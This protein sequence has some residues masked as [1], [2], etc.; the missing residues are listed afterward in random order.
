MLRGA[1][2]RSRVVILDG[3]GLPLESDA[4]QSL[5]SPIKS[6]PMAEV[7]EQRLTTTSTSIVRSPLHQSCREGSHAPLT[8]GST[9]AA[10]TFTVA[11]RRAPGLSPTASGTRTQLRKSLVV[12]R[13]VLDQRLF[14]KTCATSSVSHRDDSQRVASLS[15]QPDANASVGVTSA[16][17]TQEDSDDVPSIDP[18]GVASSTWASCFSQVQGKTYL[19]LTL[20]MSGGCSNATFALP[21]G[22][23]DD[24]KTSSVPIDVADTTCLLFIRAVRDFYRTGIRFHR[25]N[26]LRKKA[27]MA[28]PMTTTN[29]EPPPSATSLS[30][31]LAQSTATSALRLKIRAV[32]EELVT[33]RRVKRQGSADL[34]NWGG[35]DDTDRLRATALSFSGGGVRG[36]SALEL[37][38]LGPSIMP[39]QTAHTSDSDSDDD[40]SSLSEIPAESIPDRQLVDRF[41]QSSLEALTAMSRK[42][43]AQPSVRL[44]AIRVLNLCGCHLGD[45]G[46]FAVLQAIRFGPLKGVQCLDLMYNQLTTRS[47]FYMGVF[48]LLRPPMTFVYTDTN[49]ALRATYEEANIPL[50]A[51]QQALYLIATKRATHRGGGGGGS[52]SN[53]QGPPFFMPL[54]DSWKNLLQEFF[55]KRKAVASMMSPSGETM[56][57]VPS[58]FSSIRHVVHATFS[59]NSL[60][61][62]RRGSSAP[63]ISSLRLPQGAA[64]VSLC[65]TSAAVPVVDEETFVEGDSDDE[66]FGEESDDDDFEEHLQEL[67]SILSPK[68]HIASPVASDTP[69]RNPSITTPRGATAESGSQGLHRQLR[70]L[71]DKEIHNAAT[72]VVSLRLGWNDLQDSG[73]TTLSEWLSVQT[74]LLELNVSYND[75]SDVG[76]TALRD[77]LRSTTSLISLNTEGNMME[78]A[79]AEVMRGTLLYNRRLHSKGMEA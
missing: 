29:T 18:S 15:Q 65:S 54:F 24:A 45:D 11:A 55:S 5:E 51:R 73:I 74:F 53:R 8:L 36:R 26:G 35:D 20:D 12:D 57:R 41:T 19:D 63:D 4:G 69:S 14:F 6:P 2:K 17:T 46:C 9:A 75:A 30:A 48:L 66:D 23:D 1:G 21:S 27:H 77:A 22:L 52:T 47:V 61:A 59:L 72:D 62:N 44:Q 64:S 38:L 68:N 42:L 16:T 40:T 13:T 71:Q 43:F 79:T 78:D 34:S 32:E 50:D 28:A 31:K 58:R 25:R 33:M 39:K 70:E 3:S 76:F 56:I 49:A 37:I 67:K 10:V 7:E 60:K